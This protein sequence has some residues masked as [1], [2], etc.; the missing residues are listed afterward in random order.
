MLTA[1]LPVAEQ[2]A[3]S[4]KSQNS[5]GVNHQPIQIN[6][7]LPTSQSEDNKKSSNNNN[8]NMSFKIKQENVSPDETNSE[9]LFY[10]VQTLLSVG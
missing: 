2:L 9:V 4:G 5:D 3:N 10:R 7:M 8:N 6:A 1:H